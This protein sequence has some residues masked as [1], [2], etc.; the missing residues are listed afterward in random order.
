MES[1]IC[2][3]RRRTQNPACAS[4][5]NMTNKLRSL[6]SLQGRVP[7]AHYFL[8]G[9]LLLVLKFLIDHTI[10]SRF[11]HS[12]H[13]WSYFFPPAD[14]SIFGLGSSNPRFYLILTGSPQFRSS[15]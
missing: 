9:S 1:C 11:G 10:A 2:L 5:P 8:A 12:W 13:I 6:F 14:L 7:R 15:G 4:R 3:S